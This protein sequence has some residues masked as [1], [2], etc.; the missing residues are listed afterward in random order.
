MVAIVCFILS[1]LF[2]ASMNLVG[3][4]YNDWQFWMLLVEFAVY[5]IV[6]ALVAVL[7]EDAREHE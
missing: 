5:G 4:H 3:F 2:C 7:R 1:G 6:M